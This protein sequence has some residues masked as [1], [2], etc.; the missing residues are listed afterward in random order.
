MQLL[1]TRNLTNEPAL[2]LQ[3]IYKKNINIFM[4]YISLIDFKKIFVLHQVQHIKV[5]KSSYTIAQE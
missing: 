3:N 5:K 2:V 1:L 4:Y